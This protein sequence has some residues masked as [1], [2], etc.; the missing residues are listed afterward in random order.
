MDEPVTAGSAPTAATPATG[1]TLFVLN[2][3]GD[4][5]KDEADDD[6]ELDW[7]A[8]VSCLLTSSLAL[9]ISDEELIPFVTLVSSLFGL[10]LAFLA[11]ELLVFLL[12]DEVDDLSSSSSD[13]SLLLELALFSL[14]S[15]GPSDP[16]CSPSWFIWS[17]FSGFGL[18]SSLTS[19]EADVD[20]S[21]LAFAC[22]LLLFPVELLVKSVLVVDVVDEVGDDDEW[23]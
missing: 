17:F 9:V 15:S 18:L 4:V 20:F 13:S 1:S 2:G 14:S 7:K 10:V 23:I 21:S 6:G 8:F 3:T 19:V 12:D 22:L 11:D 5:D 16:F